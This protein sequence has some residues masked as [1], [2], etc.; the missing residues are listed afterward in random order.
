M[1]LDHRL[2]HGAG[3]DPHLAGMSFGTSGVLFAGLL[4]GHLGQQQAWQMPSGIGE[5]GLVLFVYAVG[6]GAGPTFF[7]AFRDQGRQLAFLGMVT[8]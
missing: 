7:R 4:F 2:W 6:L 5:M 1:L 3:V 8:V